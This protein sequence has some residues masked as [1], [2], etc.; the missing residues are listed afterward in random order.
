MCNSNHKGIS[1][2][3]YFPRNIRIIIN[4]LSCTNFSIKMKVVLRKTVSKYLILGFLNLKKY[5]YLKLVCEKICTLIF[6]FLHFDGVLLY[7]F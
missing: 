6:W 4:Y 5:R 7:I 2:H 3:Y 1:C